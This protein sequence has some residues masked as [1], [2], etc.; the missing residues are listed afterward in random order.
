M[1]QLDAIRHEIRSISLVNP[2]PL[3]RRLDNLDQT[4]M[5]N[6]IVYTIHDNVIV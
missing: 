2:G 3:T 6:G 5:A 1:A 4:S